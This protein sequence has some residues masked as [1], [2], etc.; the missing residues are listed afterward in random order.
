MSSW[1]FATLLPPL[2]FAMFLVTMSTRVLG[3]SC[4]GGCGGGTLVFGGFA[5]RPGVFAGRG[6]DGVRGS[7]L[8]RT[9]FASLV[10]RRGA[11]QREEK[12]DER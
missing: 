4:F 11:A 5:L 2:V 3:G 6:V 7:P 12:D 1:R 10:A 8:P 9:W